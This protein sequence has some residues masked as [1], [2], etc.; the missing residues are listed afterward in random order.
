M[1]HISR[2]R[3]PRGNVEKKVVG[4]IAGIENEDIK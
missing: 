2:I 3:V 4:N 1:L